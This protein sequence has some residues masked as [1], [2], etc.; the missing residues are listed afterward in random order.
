MKAHFDPLGKGYAESPSHAG[1]KTLGMLLAWAEPKASDLLCDVGAGTG[2]TALAFAPKV[3]FAVGVDPSSGMLAAARKASNVRWAQGVA[4]ALPLK[5]STFD[6]AV[7][8]TAAHHFQDLRAACREFRRIL[9]PG[10][11]CV[12]T[13][14]VGFDDLALQ[15]FVHGVEVLHDPSHVKAYTV[16]EWT[17]ALEEAGLKVERV[18][19]GM[20]ELPEGTSVEDWCR[21][22]GTPAMAKDEIL[23]RLKRAPEVLK[24]RR[25]GD[26]VRFNIYKLV[27]RARA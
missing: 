2:H 4:E 12:V 1:G 3:R 18:E 6:L 20:T 9:K 17:A 11:R 27:L 21:R 14:Q 8:R 26:D 22:S 19:S 7:S 23:G 10:G 16:A 5:S 13:D 24:V 25:E 15:A